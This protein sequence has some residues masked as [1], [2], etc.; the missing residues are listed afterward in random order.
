MVTVLNLKPIQ[1]KAL[2][3]RAESDRNALLVAFCDLALAPS[4]RLDA[5]GNTLV[6]PLAKVAVTRTECRQICCDYINQYV[7]EGTWT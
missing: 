4:E 5:D 2:R 3:A 6:E 7:D 1:V